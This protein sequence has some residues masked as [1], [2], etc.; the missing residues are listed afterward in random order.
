MLQA[1]GNSFSYQRGALGGINYMCSRYIV[2]FKSLILTISKPEWV[3]HREV[4]M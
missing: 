3:D 1:V 4:L 2:Q